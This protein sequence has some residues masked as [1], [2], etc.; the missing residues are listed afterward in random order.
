MNKLSILDTAASKRVNARIVIGKFS[1]QGELSKQE[2]SF[3][4]GET[5]EEYV[6]EDSEEFSAGWIRCEE[7][8][9]EDILEISL[10]SSSDIYIRLYK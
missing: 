7:L 8:K 2:C 9:E 5:W 6:I 3:E 4:T 1:F 10:M